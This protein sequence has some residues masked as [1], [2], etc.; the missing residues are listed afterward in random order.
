MTQE[1][2]GTENTPKIEDL[3]QAEVGHAGWSPDY[4]SSPGTRG[5]VA[6]ENP[7]VQ[8]PASEE[9]I[10]ASKEAA[11]RAAQEAQKT[12]QQY[13][14][15]EVPPQAAPQPAVPTPLQTDLRQLVFVGKLSEDVVVGGFTFALTTLTSKENNDAL[16][17]SRYVP[18]DLHTMGVLRI[19][20]L[21]RAIESVNGVPLESLYQGG[22]EK[23]SIMDRRETVIGNWQ[24]A[25]MTDLWMKYNDLL[26]RSEAAFT[27]PEDDLKN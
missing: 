9:R 18:G 20:V 13:T 27:V 5:R 1:H 11:A 3:T 23:L 2:E 4:Q 7:A 15:A 22:N 12:L 25:F 16:Q 14:A 26:E 17:R 6:A 24:Q 10:R 8:N 21:A 19:A